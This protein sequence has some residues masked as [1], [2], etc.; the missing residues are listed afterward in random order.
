M[1]SGELCTSTEISV[2]LTAQG[3]FCLVYA[4]KEYTGLYAEGDAD[5]GRNFGYDEFRVELTPADIDL[6]VVPNSWDDDIDEDLQD[7]DKDPYVWIENLREIAPVI[8]EKDH[9]GDIDFNF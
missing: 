6:I 3:Q 4:S 1:N 9:E 8:F 2:Q 5:A 7:T